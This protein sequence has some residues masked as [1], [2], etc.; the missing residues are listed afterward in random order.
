MQVDTPRRS[1]HVLEKE[2]VGVHDVGWT[3]AVKKGWIEDDAGSKTS[4]FRGRLADSVSSENLKR[5][6]CLVDM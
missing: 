6:R 2:N 5:A 4:I 1:C 3:V